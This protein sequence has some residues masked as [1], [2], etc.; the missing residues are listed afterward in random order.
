MMSIF[1]DVD[2]DISQWVFTIL[3]V[4]FALSLMAIRYL[5]HRGEFNA[6]GQRYSPLLPL[7][8]LCIAIWAPVMA[9]NY[10]LLASLTIEWW[11]ALAI[12]DLVLLALVFY[13]EKNAQDVDGASGW[14][15]FAWMMLQPMTILAC[16]LLKL[17]LF[18]I[19]Y[20]SVLI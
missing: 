12:T 17:S 7:L 3:M 2:W 13:F 10:W 19:K 16:V 20:F 4:V 8:P 5:K 9:V 11:L 15:T 6:H 1:L 18:L 14:M